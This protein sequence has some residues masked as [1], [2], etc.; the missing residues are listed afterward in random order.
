M[1]LNIVFEKGKLHSDV[2]CDYLKDQHKGDVGYVV[3][4][5]V[6]IMRMYREARSLVM[7]D[8]NTL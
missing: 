4:Q 1:I 2:I 6:Y 3:G 7:K 5:D 8:P